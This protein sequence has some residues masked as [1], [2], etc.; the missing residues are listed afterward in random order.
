M[1][2]TA[3]LD[4]CV[5]LPLVILSDSR[6]WGVAGFAIGASAGAAAVDD[7]AASASITLA[8]L[9]LADCAELGAAEAAPYVVVVEDAGGAIADFWLDCESEFFSLPAG[10]KER[11]GRGVKIGA[12]AGVCVDEAPGATPGD[13]AACVFRCELSAGAAFC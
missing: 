4:G 7:L 6:F 3:N 2:A 9:L 10:A 12:T 1:G 11:L 5:S 13:A 8:A